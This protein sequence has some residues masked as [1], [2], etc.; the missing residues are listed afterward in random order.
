MKILYFTYFSK[1]SFGPF[2][3]FI[4]Y[5]FILFYAYYL[6]QKKKSLFTFLLYLLGINYFIIANNIQLH[7]HENIIHAI[8]MF[9]NYLFLDFY[10]LVFSPEFYIWDFYFLENFVQIFPFQII[11]FGNIL[12]RNIKSYICIILVFNTIQ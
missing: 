5:N 2:S 7:N 12:F 9:S 3:S 10:V 8:D 11:A 6:R 4:F 1:F